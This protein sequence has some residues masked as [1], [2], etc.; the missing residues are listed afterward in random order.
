MLSAISGSIS[1]GEKRAGRNAVFGYCGTLLLGI[2]E[3]LRFSLPNLDELVWGGCN[4]PSVHANG[5]FQLADPAPGPAHP[6]ASRLRVSAPPLEQI[7]VLQ[8]LDIGVESYPH[9]EW[10][11]RDADKIC[12]TFLRQQCRRWRSYR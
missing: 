11:G 6:V 2:A 10:Q 3:A 1:K 4:T 12:L 7:W 9:S 5:Y 8:S